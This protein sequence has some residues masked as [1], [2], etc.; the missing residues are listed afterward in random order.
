MIT[1]AIVDL[2]DVQV[3]DNHC[4]AVERRAA[5]LDGNSWR[6]LFSESPDRYMQTVNVADTVFYQ[7]L[8]TAL[9]DFHDVP[10]TEAAVLGAR[11]AYDEAELTGRLLSDARIG[12]LVLDTGFPDPQH[13]L[14]VA[15]MAGAAGCE[16]VGL[17]RLEVLFQRLVVEH[18]RY[19]AVVEELRAALTGL[20]GKGYAGFKSIVAYRTGLDIARWSPAETQAAFAAARHEVSSSGAVRLGFAPLLDS[21]L[22]IAFEIAAA[23]ELPVQFHV[24]YGDPDADLRRANPLELRSILEE[25]AYRSM[26]VVLLHSCW[27]FVREGAYLAA[28][29]GNAYLDLSYG[30]PFLSRQEMRAATRA[31]LAAA[32]TSKLMYS[33]DGVW[34]PEL[35]WLAAHDGRLLLGQVLAE[36]VEDGDLTPAQARAAGEQVLRDNATALYGLVG[37]YR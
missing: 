20:R 27:P 14:S 15:E 32:P 3:V 5:Q 16:T 30:I 19:D 18:E 35:H 34:V 8:I 13:A 2:Q 21:L 1:R 36:L 23:E 28:V 29:Y 9:A 33:S 31:A 7:R 17:L 10:A 4:H 6:A 26:P 25:P 22:H 24:G 37:S 12:A 11:A